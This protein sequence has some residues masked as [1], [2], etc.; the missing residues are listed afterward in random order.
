MGIFSSVLVCSEDPLKALLG[1]FGVFL[2][3][4]PGQINIKTLFMII[5]CLLLL[6]PLL[7]LRRRLRRLRRLY[8]R[9]RPRVRRHRR[10]LDHIP[11]RHGTPKH[12]DLG[13]A[14]PRSE[15]VG[16]CPEGLTI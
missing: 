2:G 7:L 12:G 3:Q 13:F 4:R 9:R 15:R 14:D 16:G 5:V 10:L 1:S 8:C 11:Q 6:L